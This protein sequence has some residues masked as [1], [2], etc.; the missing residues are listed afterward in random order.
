ME[1]REALER[2]S[3]LQDGG[4]DAVTGKAVSLHLR[5]CGECAAAARSL[6]AVRET[7]R[8]LPPT[9][10][11]PELLERVREAAAR[12][13]AGA[14]AGESGTSS[15]SPAKSSR[16]RRWLPLEAAAAVLLVA[17]WLVCALGYWWFQRTRKGF[18]D[19]L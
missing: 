18:A 13:G 19:V 11:P 6:A 8:S 17:S 15:G 10:A 4:V 2:L 14:A 3:D 7:L 16:S 12:E 1:C 9:P 5:E